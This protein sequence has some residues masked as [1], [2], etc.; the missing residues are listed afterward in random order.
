MLFVKSSLPINWIQTLNV[1]KV[2]IRVHLVVHYCGQKSKAASGKFFNALSFTLSLATLP[3][4][5]SVAVQNC[6]LTSL[7]WAI[8]TFLDCATR[9]ASRWPH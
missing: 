8:K 3:A 7:V 1:I 6:A 9:L 4:G 5:T 2:C